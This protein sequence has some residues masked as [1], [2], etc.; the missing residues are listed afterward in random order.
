MIMLV[1]GACSAGPAPAPTPSI[2]GADTG[3]RLL[4]WTRAQLEVQA[5][6]LVDAYNATHT[7]QVELT[8]V[9][10]LP[11]RV[12]A[13]A[14]TGA[15]PDLFAG[16]VA[17]VPGWTGRGLYRDLG[18]DLARLPFA[19]R[20]D[21]ASVKAGDRHALPFVLT[22][23]GTDAIGISRDSKKAGQAWNF[24]AW[25]LSDEAQIQVLARNGDR[26]ARADLQANEFATPQKGA[27]S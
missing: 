11:A 2:D 1:L 25:V 19:D 16:A 15:L 20:L 14:T 17:D 8:L 7:N 10:D 26:V 21:P 3:G 24:I 23:K 27:S 18:A 6:L 4:L 9:A 22:D 5:T 12:D 13:A